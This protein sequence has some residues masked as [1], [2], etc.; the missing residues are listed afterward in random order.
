MTKTILVADD[1]K[2]I[3][4]VVALTFRAT[5]FRVISVSDA[6]EALKRMNEARPDVVL[7]DVAMPG[8]NGYDLCSQIKNG[9]ATANV[10]VL[11]LAGAFEP[12][13]D[14]RAAE[15]RADGHIKKPFDSQS[16][17]D[18]VKALTGAHVGTEMPMSFAASLAA[19]QKVDDAHPIHAGA[20]ASAN[21][22]H[23]ANAGAHPAPTP[24]FAQGAFGPT[25]NPA[26]HTIGGAAQASAGAARALAPPPSPSA[27]GYARTGVAGNA[28]IASDLGVPNASRGFGSDTSPTPFGPP[29]QEAR[30]RASPR[31]E[32]RA[33][34]PEEVMIEEPEIIEDAEVLD[35]QQGMSLESTVPSLEPP[36]SPGESRPRGNV[37]V[38]S[39]AEVPDR[40]TAGAR[41]EQVTREVAP[42]TIAGIYADARAAEQA[43][44][45]NAD[46]DIQAIEEVALDEI[47]IAPRSRA[48]SDAAKA[49]GDAAAEP[50]ARAAGERV[51]GL[52]KDEL[53]AM[54]REAIERI[55]WEVVPDLA[56]AIIKAEINRLLKERG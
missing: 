3:Q 34:R 22:G 6:D 31:I 53:V 14:R 49:I 33:A 15:A 30:D 45:Q 11:L 25:T 51:P 55:A 8:K 1:S 19:R 47:P 10:P 7:A 21:A 56:E 32:A 52:P 40:K 24:S 17:I 41:S 46:G 42:Q 23:G 2:T 26:M 28:N 20:N 16:L 48:A 5:D 18:R 44:R 54:A 35:D 12:F 13:D 9:A 29:R 38:W 50:V 27:G 4:K 37:D 36:P 43:S 39:L